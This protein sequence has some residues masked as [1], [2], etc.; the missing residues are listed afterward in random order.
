M[1]ND[2]TGAMSVAGLK[3]GGTWATAVTCAT[4]DQ[5]NGVQIT[6][7]EN[8]ETLQVP[9]I[10]SGDIMVNQTDRGGV[11]PTFNISGPLGYNTP[12]W[13]AIAQEFGTAAAPMTMGNGAYVHSILTNE[14]ANSTFYTFAF[15]A[16]QS[17][18]GAIEYPS[19]VTNKT[20]INVPPPT[21]YLTA[22]IDGLANAQTVGG[23][24]NTYAG[25]NATTAVNT[26]R[27]VW[28][29]SD[30]LKINAQAG[31][32]LGANDIYSVQSIVISYDRPQEHPREATGTAGNGVPTATGDFPLA[33][34]LTVTFKS[35]PELRFFTAAQAGTEYKASITQTG[36]LIGGSNYYFMEFNFPRVK[37]LQS[38]DYP[39]TSGGNNPLTV[40]FTAMV[41]A[42][43]PTGMISTYPY[44]RVQNDRS[45]SFLA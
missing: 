3:I 45:T 4:G 27:A 37:I 15:N 21:A 22:A 32:A 24:T 18:L 2:L 29:L 30:T 42:S 11:A 25:L 38:P 26:K 31:G 10:G 17:A 20:T 8:A 28:Q 16:C 14:T 6:H 5:L 33:V 9:P 43:N 23:T 13:T 41:A 44:I 39:L 40:V 7:N 19:C 1:A 36:S 34:S 12:Q 35:L